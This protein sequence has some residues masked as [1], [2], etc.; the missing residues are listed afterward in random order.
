MPDYRLQ[1]LLEMRQRAEKEAQD[2]LQEEKK[3]LSAEK[4]KLQDLKDQKQ[5][6]IE[7]RLARRDEL[8]QK[9]RSGQM[10]VKKVQEEYRYLDRM[11]QEITAMD[12]VIYRQGEVV[13]GQEV[14]VQRALEVLVEKSK[15]LKAIE[16]HKE[17]WQKEVKA[18]R[19][20]IEEDRME[21]VGQNIFMFNK[22]R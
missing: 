13:R 6:M 4:K 18:E 11:A 9:M 15:E 19:Q 12:D 3:R 20:R 7:A 14:E 10:A 22:N 5:Q 17:K 8:T 21:E 1:V 16:K 2:K